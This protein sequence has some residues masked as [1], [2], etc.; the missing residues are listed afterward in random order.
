VRAR[1]KAL[2]QELR[3]HDGKLGERLP[4]WEK[5]LTEAV[6]RSFKP[7][8]QTVLALPRRS[9]VMCSK[10]SCSTSTWPGRRPA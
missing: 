4:E 1:V 9:G 7:E 3:A 8:V 6:R 5:A 2:Q 10:S